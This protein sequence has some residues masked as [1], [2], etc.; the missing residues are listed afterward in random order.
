[1]IFGEPGKED[2]GLPASTGL[3]QSGDQCRAGF[4]DYRVQAFFLSGQ[5]S[6][7]VFSLLF[8]NLMPRILPV[9]LPTQ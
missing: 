3:S 1:M 6:S 9:F 2:A 5:S 8:K 4:P 7:K